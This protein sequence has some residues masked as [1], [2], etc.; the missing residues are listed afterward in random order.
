MPVI[1][2]KNFKIIMFCG[3]ACILSG[4]IVSSVKTFAGNMINGSTH[5]SHTTSQTLSVNGSFSFNNIKIE[6]DLKV[7][8]SLKG[9][10]LICD[11]LKVNGSSDIQKAALKTSEINGSFRGD[12]ITVQGLFK[13]NGNLV[14]ENSHF[15]DIE[16]KGREISLTKSN[17]KSIVIKKYEEHQVLRLDNS[18]IN[19]DVTF[20][21]GDGEI[22]LKGDSSIKGAIK[23]AKVSKQ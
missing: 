2:K 4:Y 18:I 17:S 20:E 23:G 13:I 8:G 19:N 22:I 7:N 16:A 6:G 15:E 3:M 1:R 14:V 12:A 5:L 9:N 21:S 10:D 11:S